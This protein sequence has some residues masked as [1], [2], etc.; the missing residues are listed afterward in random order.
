MDHFE[1]HRTHWA[2]KDGDIPNEVIERGFPEPPERDVVLVSSEYFEALLQNKPTRAEVLKSEIETFPPSFEKAREFLRGNFLEHKLFEALQHI[3][4]TRK[5]GREHV[6]AAVR[7]EQLEKL[8]THRPFSVIWLLEQYSAPTEEG[9][10]DSLVDACEEILRAVLARQ[11]GQQTIAEDDLRPLWQSIRCRT[12]SLRLRRIL[13]TLVDSFSACQSEEGYWRS[14]EALDARITAMMAVIQ[15]RLGNDSHRE[16]IRKAVVWLCSYFSFDKGTPGDVV[17]A[18]LTLEAVRRSGMLDQLKHVADAGD[19]WLLACQ[20]PLGSWKADGWH[21]GDMTVLVLDY[22]SQS[23]TMLGQVDGFLL[24]SRDF[25]RKAQELAFEGGVNN[26]RLAAIAAVH[27]MEMFLYGLF[28]QRDDFGISAYVERGD[29]TLGPRESLAALQRQ[30]QTE[31]LLERNRQL[32]Y[33]DQLSGFVGHRDMIIHR[34][35][36]ISAEELRRGLK[37]VEGFIRRY[38]EDLLTRDLL[39]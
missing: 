6:Q 16:G 28:E 20:Q 21:A 8:K 29:Q 1:D 5:D 39:Q 30:M 24:M 26:R 11:S 9:I 15:Q 14:A 33:R 36:E 12:L 2:I 32:S 27:A 19:A 22:F 34:A 37:A 17:T 3:G 7:E 18:T 4:A 35:S 13:N 38:G 25:F 31:G 23:P 10:V